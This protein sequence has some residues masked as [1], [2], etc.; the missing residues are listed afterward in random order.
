[1]WFRSFKPSHTRLPRAEHWGSNVLSPEA[2]D[3][4]DFPVDQKLVGLR[5]LLGFVT[6]TCLGL[7]CQSSFCPDNHVVIW[8]NC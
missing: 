4:P 6:A 5:Q 8:V 2:E 7:V 3:G 1:M